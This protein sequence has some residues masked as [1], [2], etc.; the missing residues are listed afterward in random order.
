MHPNFWPNTPDINPFH[1]Q[2]ANESKYIQR[3]ALAATLSSSVGIYGPVFEYMI[4]TPLPNREEYLNSEKFQITH[5]DWDIKNNLIEIISKINKIRK[6]EEALQQTNNIK[7]CH[8]DNDNLIAFYK[9]ND[10][11]TSEILVIINLDPSNTQN[12][13]MQLPL[14]DIKS[15]EYGRP[16][17][18][19]DFISGNS[20]NWYDEWCYIELQADLPL[21]IFKINK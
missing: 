6:E 11:K 14:S 15:V 5:Y 18:V 10:S 17:Q 13:S 4:D 21:H 8:I 2:G 19:Y 12:G 7:F 16:V 1:L 3:Y 9:W 20:Y